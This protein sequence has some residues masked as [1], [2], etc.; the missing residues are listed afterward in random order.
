MSVF[1]DDK[2]PSPKPP[3]ASQPPSSKSIAI[4]KQ[5]IPN[6]AKDGWTDVAWRLSNLAKQPIP[7]LNKHLK[8]SRK[9]SNS[10]IWTV[11]QYGTSVNTGQKIDEYKEQVDK[12][13]Q[14]A[15][16]RVDEEM[17]GEDVE[18]WSKPQLSSKDNDTYLL[19]LEMD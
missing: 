17:P 9:I 7:Q 4:P 5:K 13:I 11:S 16:Q 15:Q 1:F 10:D 18:F 19:N 3:P 2:L 6:T 14:K 8:E 12:Q